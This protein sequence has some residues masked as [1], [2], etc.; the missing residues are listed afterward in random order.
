MHR[1]YENTWN[2]PCRSR[3]FA[4]AIPHCAEIGPEQ[5]LLFMS[6]DSPEIPGV[7]WASYEATCRSMRSTDPVEI[8]DGTW[9]E[10]PGMSATCSLRSTEQKNIIQS[11]RFIV[12]RLL[13]TVL[14]CSFEQA[15]QLIG[16]QI[17]RPRDRV[18]LVLASQLEIVCLAFQTPDQQCGHTVETQTT[19]QCKVSYW[20]QSAELLLWS[21]LHSLQKKGRTRTEILL[22]RAVLTCFDARGR[23]C[24]TRLPGITI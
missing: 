18:L 7:S 6:P 8:C 10:I 16:K 12:L 9:T 14:F 22:E 3:A 4:S 11:P 5:D 21:S 15:D 13:Y 23:N 20:L 17:R 19:P 24:F 1:H 2:T